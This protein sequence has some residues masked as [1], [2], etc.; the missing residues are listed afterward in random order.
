MYQA[1][2]TRLQFKC[3]IHYDN[4]WTGLEVPIDICT[5][6]ADW[7]RSSYNKSLSPLGVHGFFPLLE[8]RELANKTCAHQAHGGQNPQARITNCQRAWILAGLCRK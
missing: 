5:C 8:G 1:S 4:E 7:V 3:V 6:E 2:N